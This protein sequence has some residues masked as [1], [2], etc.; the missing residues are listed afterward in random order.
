MYRAST[1]INTVHVIDWN[2]FLEM[3][4]VMRSK[5]SAKKDFCKV[6]KRISGKEKGVAKVHDSTALSTTSTLSPSPS[7]QSHDT[8][9]CC[10]TTV[11]FTR[12][13]NK[14]NQ[15]VPYTG[16]VCEFLLTNPVD[17]TRSFLTI[18]MRVRYSPL[19]YLLLITFWQIIFGKCFV[20]LH[21]LCNMIQN[22]GGRW[23]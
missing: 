1:W 15:Y 3:K 17:S 14:S 7:Q 20:I 13:V 19:H 16:L 21:S 22:S 10:A 4:P 2:V 5:D 11:F 9:H 18:H 6:T 23:I 8:M 12:R